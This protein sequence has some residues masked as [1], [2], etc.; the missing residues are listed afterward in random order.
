MKAGGSC[1]C[2]TRSLWKLLSQCSKPS[3][4][5]ITSVK[6]DPCPTP[7]FHH[8]LVGQANS[9]INIE[10]LTSSYS[11]PV[12]FCSRKIIP[13][14]FSKT[15]KKSSSSA[16]SNCSLQE[17]DKA[18]TVSLQKV[19]ADVNMTGEGC[20]GARHLS[21]VLRSPRPHIRYL[22]FPKVWPL[23]QKALLM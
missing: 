8:L 9:I 5:S 21:L 23:L 6:A 7:A 4:Y 19:F 3:A 12:N 2:L 14:M 1:R 11:W 17:K 20:S 22:L 16:V 15:Q 18:M 13:S 10:R